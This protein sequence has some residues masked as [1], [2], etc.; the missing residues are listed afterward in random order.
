MT[1]KELED[2]DLVV[3]FEKKEQNKIQQDFPQTRCLLLGRFLRFFF[4]D[5]I[6]WYLGDFYPSGATDI[7]DPI[8][9]TDK[10]GQ[11]STIKRPHGSQKDTYYVQ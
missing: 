1:Q 6:D 10:K 3:C 7:P 5:A 11:S 8:G 9:L 4:I 2:S